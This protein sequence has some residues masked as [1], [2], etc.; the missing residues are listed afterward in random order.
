M[1]DH[2]NKIVSLI[3][4][5]LYLFFTS[6]EITWMQTVYS[7]DPEDTAEAAVPV[8]QWTAAEPI[9]GCCQIVTN[10]TL[11]WLILFTNVSRNKKKDNHQ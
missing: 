6:H 10:V 4:N 3:F 11:L 8:K 7:C 2:V 5:C 9:A 1:C